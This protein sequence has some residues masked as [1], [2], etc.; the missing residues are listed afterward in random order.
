MNWLRIAKDSEAMF[1][2]GGIAMDVDYVD[3]SADVA[4]GKP[5]ARG[6]FFNCVDDYYAFSGSKFCKP[7]QVSDNELTMLLL[8]D[9]YSFCPEMQVGLALKFSQCSRS[10]SKYCSS[11]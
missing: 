3:G 8:L 10:Y 2:D 9:I 6:S 4:F 5:T 1:R 11:R 7:H